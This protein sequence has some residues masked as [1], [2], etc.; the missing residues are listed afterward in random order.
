[1]DSLRLTPQSAFIF[2]D[3]LRVKILD[4]V[5]HDSIFFTYPGMSLDKY[6]V[7]MDTSVTEILGTND[8]GLANFVKFNYKG[9]G[10]LYIHL[11]PATFTN[12][13]LL[14]KNNKRYYDEALSYLPA[15]TKMVNWDDYF[16][17]HQN[18][19]KQGGTGNRTFSKLSVF[20]KDPVLRWAVWL[21]LILFL[22]IYLFESKRKQRI[23]PVMLPLKNASVDFVKTIGRLY[24]Q[25]KDN[26]NLA[27]KMNSHF[28]DHVRNTYNIPTSQ[29]DEEFV[30]RLSYKSGLSINVVRDIVNEVKSIDEE[31]EIGDKQLL[32]L[33]NKLENFYKRP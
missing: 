29:L 30:K 18:G 10:S 21:S 11:A 15:N 19:R 7:D 32:Q 12:F 24:F 2:R 25:R 23:I 1:M 20:L 27:S 33:S 3:S 4:P 5:S 16:R 9:G 22:I 28:L 6:L 14:H 13:F 26:K 8:N 31:P 17:Y